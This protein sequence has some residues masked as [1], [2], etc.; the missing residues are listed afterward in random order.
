MIKQPNSSRVI[1]FNVGE[2]ALQFISLDKEEDRKLFLKHYR[3][4]DQY[5]LV[6]YLTEKGLPDAANLIANILDEKAN[7]SGE[8][9]IL[10]SEV[11]D[12]E[13]A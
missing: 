9:Q 5:Y 4:N 10:E 13:N 12:V 7:H 1:D 2:L 3:A 8:S 6:D 11:S